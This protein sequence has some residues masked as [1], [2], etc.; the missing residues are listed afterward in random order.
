MGFMMSGGHGREDR[1]TRLLAL[2]ALRANL[3]TEPNLATVT[4]ER[5]ELS[6][7][8]ILSLF[9]LTVPSSVW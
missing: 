1:A 8:N 4:S 3:S 5:V 9:F 6:G 2:S 7:F